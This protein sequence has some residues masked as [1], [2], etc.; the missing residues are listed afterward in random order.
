MTRNFARTLGAAALIVMLG[1]CASTDTPQNVTHVS[2]MST[3]GYDNGT[4][5]LWAPG[6]APAAAADSPVQAGTT[7]VTET[8]EPAP[9]TTEAAA[10]TT[11]ETTTVTEP[12]T[13][14]VTTPVAP[15]PA[16]A[17]VTTPAEPAPPVEEPARPMTR[18]D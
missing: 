12:T 11:T 6:S 3:V 4:P 15:E 7:E 18:K 16:T 10:S 5:N 8:T 2:S 13:E 14:T 9:T 17:E 1:A